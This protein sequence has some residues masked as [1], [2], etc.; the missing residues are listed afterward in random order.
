LRGK[1]RG[2]RNEIL[3]CRVFTNDI[4]LVM[5]SFIYVV[6]V[7]GQDLGRT[8]SSVNE[9]AVAIFQQIIFYFIEH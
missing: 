5:S 1:T 2:G 8:E 3:L 6:L 9:L 4:L 7:V